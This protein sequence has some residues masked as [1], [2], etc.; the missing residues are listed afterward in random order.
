MGL[1]NPE[2]RA[3]GGF[4]L[5]RVEDAGL[6]NPRMAVILGSGLGKA[7]P[8][9]E[10]VLEIPFNEIPGMAKCNVPGHEG[11]LHFG[12]RGVSPVLVQ[13]GRFHYYQ[14]LDMGQVTLPV[15][16]MASIGVERVF[17]IN[18]AGALNPAYDRGSM[19]LVRDH[20]NL[21]GA[22]PL[23]G[24]C[25]I[26]GNPAFQEL[27]SLYDLDAG[28]DLMQRS[29][30]SSWPLAEGVLVTMSGPSYE[31]AAELRFIRLVGGDAVSMSIV[32]EAIVARFL[33]MS[34]TA[35][36]VIT[37]IWDL[38]RP[39]K[40]SHDEVLRT[41]EEASPVLKEIITAWL[42]RSAGLS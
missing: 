38:R 8:D 27:S 28:D 22:N 33:G 2:E 40:V 21:M 34:V 5:S 24:F 3:A 13:L 18:T 16:L 32:P 10:N 9:I 41:A 25:D 36:S 31:T 17:M 26:D 6:S 12:N 4:L 39:H 37:N 7:S 11:L 42:D 15:R 23:R 1:N 19:M 20:I 14:G 29:Q 35:L 30:L